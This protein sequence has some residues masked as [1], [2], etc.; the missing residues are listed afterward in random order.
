MRVPPY[1]APMC[2]AVLCICLSSAMRKRV[3]FPCVLHA[4]LLPM[5]L[6]AY[7]HGAHE[8]G[9]AKLN[10]AVDDTHVSISLES[11]LA[12]LLSFERIPATL[13]QKKQVRDMARRMHQAAT[14]FQLT[15]AAECRFVMATLASDILDAELLDPNIPLEP[16]HADEGKERSGKEK[17]TSK[18]EHGDLDAN[19]SFMCAKPGNL[20]SVDIRLF[21]VWPNLEKIEARAVTPRGQRAASLTAR[22][23]VL[24]W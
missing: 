5:S 19:F 23:H 12:N 6:F 18:E 14:L 2:L 22:K 24:S 13:E 20:H 1:S 17:K 10:I 15:P 8:H 7:A 21:T 9:A 16:A 11:P 3:F 4:L